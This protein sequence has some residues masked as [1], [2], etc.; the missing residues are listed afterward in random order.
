MASFRFPFRGLRSDFARS[1]ASSGWADLGQ[2]LDRNFDEIE[3]S[4]GS[5]REIGA[6]GEPAF[7]NWWSNYVAPFASAAY[8][9][10]P[11]TDLVYIR[12]LIQSGNTGVP[13]FTLPAGSRPTDLLV[14]PAL[15]ATSAGVEQLYRVDVDSA[16]DLIVRGPSIPNYVAINICFRA[17]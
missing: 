4:A 7:V 6:A 5:W 1:A 8:F 12:G 17:S 14:F 9:K 15:G 13:A 3:R 16:G 10:H 11:L 2:R